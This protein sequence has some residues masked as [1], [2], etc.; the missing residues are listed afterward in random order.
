VNEIEFVGQKASL[1]AGSA[2]CGPVSGS[3]TVTLTGVADNLHFNG[4]SLSGG[5]SGDGYVSRVQI[6]SWVLG[7]RSLVMNNFNGDFDARLVMFNKL[8]MTDSTV[9]LSY[10]A[11]RGSVLFDVA[12]WDME[13]S[14]LSGCLGF[15]DFTGDTLN[16][17]YKDG[18]TVF[19][20]ESD[21]GIDNW[22]SFGLVTINGVEAEFN[23][24]D[25]YCTSDFKFGLDQEDNTRLIVTK[26][27]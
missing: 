23:G 19:D 10:N 2:I 9:N 15:N 27:S 11:G 8:S 17:I 25:A 24:V 13:E 14:T 22:Q 4:N 21:K 7:D 6:Q 20:A 26:I 1:V 3:T 5:C 16:L 12:T 18:G